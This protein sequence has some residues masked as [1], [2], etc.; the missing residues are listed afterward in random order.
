MAWL[1]NSEVKESVVSFSVNQFSVSMMAASDR[2]HF[3]FLDFT[4]M[5]GSLMPNSSITQFETQVRHCTA[6]KDGCE[7]IRKLADERMFFYRWHAMKNGEPPYSYTG[8]RRE[9]RVAIAA[10]G[11]HGNPRSTDFS[12][13]KKGEVGTTTG[14]GETLAIT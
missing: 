11:K 7:Q 2:G 10:S 5:R 12:R 9:T 3:A 13:R 14:S 8:S 6:C 4:S 1:L